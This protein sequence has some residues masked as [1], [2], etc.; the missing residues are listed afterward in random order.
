[1]HT[2]LC[3]GVLRTLTCYH[4]M[5]CYG[6]TNQQIISKGKYQAVDKAHALRG[7]ALF[8]GCAS[9]LCMVPVCMY[10]LTDQCIPFF[11]LVTQH[12]L[13]LLTLSQNGQE[14]NFCRCYYSA[15]KREQPST[16]ESPSKPHTHRKEKKE[17]KETP[18]AERHP[19][20]WKG[21]H[22]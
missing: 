11:L 18:L 12:P 7:L 4:G 17:N 16:K 15:W 21:K 10:L 22:N 13:H 20:N 3:W 9:P 8:N 5:M 19:S 6:I 1:M 14:K 2:F